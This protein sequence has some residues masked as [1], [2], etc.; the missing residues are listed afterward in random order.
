MPRAR[1]GLLGMPTGELWNLDL[2]A[3]R[4]PQDG[5]RRSW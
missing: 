2:L 4:A 1:I 3:A 5:R